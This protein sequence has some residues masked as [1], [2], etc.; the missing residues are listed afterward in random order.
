MIERNIAT[1]MLTEW[2]DDTGAFVR[3]ERFAD[4]DPVATA[5]VA[6]QEKTTLNRRSLR[7]KALAAFAGNVAYLGLRAPTQGQTTTQVQAL[8]GQFNLLIEIVYDLAGIDATTTGQM[9]ASTTRTTDR[10]PTT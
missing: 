9:T 1:G 2:D 6:E 10:A 8:T 3:E 5:L 7:E 4:P